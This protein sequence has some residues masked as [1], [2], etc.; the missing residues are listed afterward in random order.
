MDLNLQNQYCHFFDEAAFEETDRPGF[1][2]RVIT[3]DHLQLWFWRIKGGAQG[4]YLHHHVDSEQLGIVIRGKLNMRIGAKD[5][6]SRV[7]FGPG[8]LYL[9][10][11]GVWHGDSVFIGDEELDEVWILDVFSPIRQDLTPTAAPRD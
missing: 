6:E 10:P 5:D 1:R 11:M 9:A 2:R 3:G 4:S 8:E 7:T